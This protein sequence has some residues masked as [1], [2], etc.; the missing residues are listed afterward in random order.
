MLH[1]QNNTDAA[2]RCAYLVDRLR[3]QH[4]FQKRKE[5]EANICISTRVQMNKNSRYDL[6]HVLTTCLPNGTHRGAALVHLETG[7]IQ[8]NDVLTAPPRRQRESNNTRLGSLFFQLDAAAAGS[9]ILSRMLPKYRKY[10]VCRN[11]TASVY[12]LRLAIPNMR[13]CKRNCKYV[14]QQTVRIGRKARSLL[15]SPTERSRTQSSAA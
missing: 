4:R 1:I 13:H 6:V 3:A 7:T 8:T 10:S 2:K 12:A 11:A 9:A 14:R 15:L 5:C